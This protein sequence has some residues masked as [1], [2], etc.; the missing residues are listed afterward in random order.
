VGLK[1]GRWGERSVRVALALLPSWV[2]STR[3]LLCIQNDSMSKGLHLNQ[4]SHAALFPISPS[5]QARH[6]LN[7][8]YDALVQPW[9]CEQTL[10][11]EVYT[12]RERA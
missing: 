11:S 1:G 5:P 8:D 4:D 2:L 10:T 3:V 9:R 6:S 12:N 7:L